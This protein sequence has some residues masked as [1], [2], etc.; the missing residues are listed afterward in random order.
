MFETEDNARHSSKS[1]PLSEEQVKPLIYQVLRAMNYLKHKNILHRDLKPENIMIDCFDEEEM[2]FIKIIDFGFS[3][4]LNQQMDEEEQLLMDSVVM[5]TM[6]YV[7]PELIE[8]PAGGLETF[9]IESDMWSLGVIVYYLLSNQHP[10]KNFKNQKI[11]I[12]K[13][14]TCDWGFYPEEVW[15]K[16]SSECKDF[17]E[18]MIEPHYDL[19]I[20]PS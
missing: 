4:D 10:F 16:I 7:A 1:H 15:N 18:K 13:I 3:L 2:P 14:T 11:L 8:R 20:T 12:Q 9:K 19:R 6:T 5:G 17:V